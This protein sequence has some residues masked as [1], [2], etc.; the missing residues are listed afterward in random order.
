MLG[1]N[2]FSLNEFWLVWLGED[3]SGIEVATKKDTVLL[4]EGSNGIGIASPAAHLHFSDGSYKVIPS[5]V[6]YRIINGGLRKLTAMLS[7][8]EFS[9]L[10]L[11][12]KNLQPNFPAWGLDQYNEALN[13]PEALVF[14]RHMPLRNQ[15]EAKWPQ[16][17]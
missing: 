3:P 14:D 15:I 11:T 5:P 13:D 9:L 2:I 1:K 4:L 6:C 7:H 8:K 10:S 16:N 17:N 12:W